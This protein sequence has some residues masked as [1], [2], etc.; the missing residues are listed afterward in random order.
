MLALEEWRNWVEGVQHPF[1]VLTDCQNLDYH[2]ETRR[3]NPRQAHFF[4]PA[5][6]SPSRIIQNLQI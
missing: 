6:I 1:L 3:L 4:L 2:C 5:S